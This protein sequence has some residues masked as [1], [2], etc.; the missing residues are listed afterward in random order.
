VGGGDILCGEVYLGFV[1]SEKKVQG[2]S[3]QKSGW[4]CRD[5]EGSSLVKGGGWEG[6]RVVTEGEGW[7]AEGGRGV[8]EERDDETR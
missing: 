2:D 5:G 4:G 8:T 3:G 1:R 6:D 7:P